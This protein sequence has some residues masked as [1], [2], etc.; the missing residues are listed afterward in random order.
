MTSLQKWNPFKFAR[1]KDDDSIAVRRDAHPSRSAQHPM[2]R[3]FEP[4]WS[5]RF[6]REPFAMAGLLPNPILDELDRFFGNFAP[7]DFQPSIDVVDDGKSVK[8]TA[9]LPGMDRDDVEIAVQEGALV[10]SGEKKAEE[11]LQTDDCYRVERWFGRFSRT[12]PLP[13]DLDLDRVEAKLTK[14]VLTVRLP[15]TGDAPQPRRI[16]IR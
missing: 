16:E 13:A 1:K 12:V 8:I 5:D 3:L 9:E 10:I 2:A 15:K 6:W 14:G 4:M 7:N 11:D